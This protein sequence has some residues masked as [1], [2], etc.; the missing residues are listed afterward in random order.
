MSRRYRD[1]MEYLRNYLDIVKTVKDI[2]R[3]YDPKSRVYVFGSVVK[4]RYTAASDID[5]LVVTDRLDKK[6]EMMVDVYHKLDAPIELHII[7]HEQMERWYM[8]F[9]DRDEIIEV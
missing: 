8:K 9:I 2:V 6:Y 5:I 4:G 3:R 1:I 7:S